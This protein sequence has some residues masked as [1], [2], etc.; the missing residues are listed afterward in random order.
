MTPR[1]RLT[2]AP[3]ALRAAE[4]DGVADGAVKTQDLADNA[5]TSAKIADGNVAAAELADNAVTSAKIQ[6][7]AV[8]TSDLANGAVNSAKIASGQVVKSIN[9]LKDDIT[10]AAGTNVTITPSGNTLTITATGTALPDGAVTTAKLADNAVT[11]AK[12]ADGTIQQSD[13]GFSVGDIAAVNAGNGLLGGATTGDATLNVGAGNGISVSADAVELNTNFTDA[14]YVN[15]GQANSITSSMIQNGAVNS[16]KIA[17]GQVVKS[18]NSLRDDVTLA[19]GANVSITPSGNTLFI[20]ATGGGGDITAVNAGSGLAGGGLSGDVTLSVANNGITSAMIQDNT[21]VN[22]DVS[23]SAAIAGT[24]ISPDF[25]SQNIVTTGRVGIGTTSLDPR[26]ILTIVHTDP[27]I[28]IRDSGDP[29]GDTWEIHANAFNEDNFGIVRFEGNSPRGSKSV[30]VTRDGNVGIGTSSPTAKLHIAG[31]T[32]LDGI[33]FPDGTLQTTAATGGGGGLTLPFSGTTSSSSDAFTVITTGTGRAANFEVR[34]PN[35]NGSAVRATTNSNGNVAAVSGT[36]TGAGLGGIFDIENPN[37]SNAALIGRTNGTG[38]ALLG[39]HLGASGDI[40]VFQNN[41]TNQARI[42]KNGRG[43][44]NGGTQTGGADVAEAFEVE[45]AIDTYGPGDVLVISTKSDRRVE[46]CSEP[47]STLVAGVYAT[48][49]GVLLSE[50]DIEATHDD[51]IPV[52]VVGVIPTKV[53][54]ENGAIRRGDL[55]V[56]SSTSGHAMKGTARDKM[57]GTIIG[58]ALQNFEGSGTGMIKVLVNVK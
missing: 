24:K 57:L 35:Q 5:V 56:T 43:F 48:K 44:F 10:L 39:N 11:S 21:I 31:T 4:A 46:K 33:K 17:S 20:S 15:E 50:R 8:G 38:T 42:D 55:L 3:F 13:L 51:T 30:V 49:P 26:K 27:E 47:Y 29:S 53:S 34:N 12:I 54:G 16:A 28:Q 32:G 9:S 23:S 7:G 18:I 22:A 52:G 58:K 14:L 41:Y 2:S 6:D 1:F 45:N 37:N 19:A 40:A 36:N 25:G